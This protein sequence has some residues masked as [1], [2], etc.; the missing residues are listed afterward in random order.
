VLSRL[1]RPTV[2]PLST[3]L[4]LMALL[5]VDGLCGP[6]YSASL[7]PRS[8]PGRSRPPHPRVD[9]PVLRHCASGHR[10]RSAR[11]PTSNIMVFLWS[12]YCRGNTETLA[13]P[14][15]SRVPNHRN[16]HTSCYMELV[17]TSF[18]SNKRPWPNA[19]L[20]GTNMLKV[21]VYLTWCKRRNID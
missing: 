17:R 8:P 16:R 10:S 19:K 5:P 7:R 12:A 1:L 3:A 15:L 18:E 20:Q 21:L 4:R 13:M 2:A 9:A 6:I 14:L 11:T